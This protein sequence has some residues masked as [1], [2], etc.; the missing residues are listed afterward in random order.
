MCASL[1]IAGANQFQEEAALIGIARQVFYNCAC[2]PNLLLS[3]PGR[4][5]LFC[6]VRLAFYMGIH[7]LKHALLLQAALSYRIKSRVGRRCGKARPLQWPAGIGRSILF[8]STLGIEPL[9]RGV[10]RM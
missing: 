8:C 6:H 10:D 3:R 9:S 5:C 4:A 2:N 7:G 1:W